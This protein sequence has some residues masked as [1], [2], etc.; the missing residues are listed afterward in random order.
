MVSRDRAVCSEEKGSAGTIPGCHT[1][2]QPH[3]YGVTDS[4]D[5][6]QM[7]VAN[8]YT[9]AQFPRHIHA[10]LVQKIRTQQAT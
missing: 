10:W 4:K 7:E 2:P 6:S 3:H 1:E 8:I 5:G 9:V